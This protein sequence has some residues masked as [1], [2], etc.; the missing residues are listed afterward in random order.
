MRN[1]YYFKFG[2][3]IKLLRIKTTTAKG[4]VTP[5][6]KFSAKNP[7]KKKWSN[8]MYSFLTEVVLRIY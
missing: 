1:N 2:F 5:H 8:K 7:V 3:E 4:F 6:Y